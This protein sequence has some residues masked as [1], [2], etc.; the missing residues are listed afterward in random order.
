MRIIKD[1]AYTIILNNK[2]IS[3]N[4]IYDTINTVD[5]IIN[6]IYKDVVTDIN[7]VDEITNYKN[8]Y[9]SAQCIY[10]IIDI[11]IWMS[12]MNN[13]VELYNQKYSDMIKYI[14][15]I[16]NNWDNYKNVTYMFLLNSINIITHI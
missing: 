14:N 13:N 9:K 1:K 7:T 16:N 6:P 15:D 8:K 3:T 5:W 4:N 12:N 2:Y 11:I 10:N